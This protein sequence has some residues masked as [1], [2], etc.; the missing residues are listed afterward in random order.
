MNKDLDYI[1]PIRLRGLILGRLIRHSRV[2]AIIMMATRWAK[3]RALNRLKRAIRP[4]IEAVR[5]AISLRVGPW[6]AL[7]DHLLVFS[8]GRTEAG[9]KMRS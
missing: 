5:E 6:G 7:S 2:A 1:F 8:Y 9:L 4:G 3:K